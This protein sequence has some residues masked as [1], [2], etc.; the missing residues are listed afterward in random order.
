M[1]PHVT[2]EERNHIDKGRRVISEETAK[3]VR[4]VLE[5]LVKNKQTWL[6]YSLFHKR[7]CSRW[8]HRNSGE[9]RPARKL[10]RRKIYV[11]VY[12]LCTQ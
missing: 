2:K 6:R 7:T 1:K 8:A 5:A 10:H 4:E 12:R 11:F 9:T 3:Q